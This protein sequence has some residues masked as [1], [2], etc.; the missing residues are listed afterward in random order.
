VIIASLTLTTAAQGVSVVDFSVFY[1][2][3][4]ISEQ[5]AFGQNVKTW[6]LRHFPQY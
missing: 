4:T 5:F 6:K 2:R 3:L 1:I